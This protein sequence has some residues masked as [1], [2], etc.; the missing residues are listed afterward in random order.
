[1]SA[2]RFEPFFFANRAHAFLSFGFTRMQSVGSRPPLYGPPRRSFFSGPF[3]AKPLIFL[4]ITL[5]SLLVFVTRQVIARDGKRRQEVCQYKS[6]VEVRAIQPPLL[7]E[8]ITRKPAIGIAFNPKGAMVCADL[9]M[10]IA[11]PKGIM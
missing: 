6:S 1:M 3:P 7:N 2:E 9:A 8:I 11:I 5:L 10:P 4:G